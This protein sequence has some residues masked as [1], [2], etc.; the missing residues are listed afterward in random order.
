MRIAEPNVFSPDAPAP[1]RSSPG[2][3]SAP[4]LPWAR[5]PCHSTIRRTLRHLFLGVNAD[6]DVLSGIADSRPSR[7]RL[8]GS[9]PC[10]FGPEGSLPVDGV[11][12]VASSLVL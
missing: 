11:F 8:P 1:P 2:A 7:F 6:R 10:R 12:L 4:S 5:L 9:F 3:S